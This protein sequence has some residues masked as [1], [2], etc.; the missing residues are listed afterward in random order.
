M[1]RAHTHLSAHD[2]EILDIDQVEKKLV[3]EF[4][5]NVCIYEKIC[6]EYAERMLRRKSRQ[7]DWSILDW[8]EVFRYDIQLTAH[9]TAFI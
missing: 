6:V 4:G 5:N 7:L 2:E 1:K 8:G 9:I 3:T